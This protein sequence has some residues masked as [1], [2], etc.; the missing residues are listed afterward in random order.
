MKLCE[1]GCGEFSGVYLRTNSVYGQVKGAP[2]RFI[3]HHHQRW[4]RHNKW[5]GG[6]SVTSEGYI[7]KRYVDHPRSSYR[8]YVREHILIAEQALGRPLPSGAVVHHADEDRGNNKNANLV[9]CEDHTY[10]MLIHKR[11]RAY[12]ATGN[13]TSVKCSHCQRWGMTGVGDMNQGK[14][15]FLS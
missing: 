13:A 1:C 5:N 11:K 10:H 6:I 15:S 14:R 12:E 8:G 7:D 3:P 2:R 9:I 4:E